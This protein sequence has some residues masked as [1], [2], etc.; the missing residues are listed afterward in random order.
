[1]DT[2]NTNTSL[3][4]SRI[5]DSVRDKVETKKLEIN[6]TVQEKLPEWKSRGQL[7]GNLARETGMEWSRKGK[8][9]VDRWRKEFNSS[10]NKDY[11]PLRPTRSPPPSPA[12]DNLGIFGMPL[13]QAVE[14]TRSSNQDTMVPAV[15]DRCIK[16]LEQ[17]GAQ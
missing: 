6:A 10:E 7:Y 11:A 16:Y 13:E 12:T 1:M 8:E 5:A 17:H 14:L 15:V 3:L 2:N 9:A 4:F